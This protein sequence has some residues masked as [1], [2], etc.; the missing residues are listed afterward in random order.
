MSMERGGS[1]WV[2]RERGSCCQEGFERA[3]GRVGGT[4]RALKSFFCRRAS[5]LNALGWHQKVKSLFLKGM[6]DDK[7]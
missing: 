2:I 6:V 1:S 7:D 3:M 5:I 4:R